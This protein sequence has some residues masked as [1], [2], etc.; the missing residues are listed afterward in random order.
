MNIWLLTKGVLVDSR[1]KAYSLLCCKRMV[2]QEETSDPENYLP[3]RKERKNQ[4]DD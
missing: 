1:Q 2:E 4:Y 3:N